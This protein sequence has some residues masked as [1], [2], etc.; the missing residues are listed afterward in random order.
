[1]SPASGQAA[2]AKRRASQDG[3]EQGR[4]PG[5]AVAVEA[6]GELQ[7]GDGTDWAIVLPPPPSETPDF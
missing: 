7:F 6:G 1:M 2:M 5:A 4:E 3:E